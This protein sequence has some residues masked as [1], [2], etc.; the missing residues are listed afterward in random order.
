MTPL[1]ITTFRHDDHPGEILVS[2]P[3]N[4]EPEKVLAVVTAGITM[5]QA[6]GRDDLL[7]NLQIPAE[8]FVAERV[9]YIDDDDELVLAD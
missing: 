8:E 3:S 1:V 2:I 5:L 6:M 4:P 7:G 9:S